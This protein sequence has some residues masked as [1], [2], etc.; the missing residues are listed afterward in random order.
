[1]GQLVVFAFKEESGAG[2]MRDALVELQRQRLINL[3]DAAVIVR[4]QDG[5]EL[6]NLPLYPSLAIG[7]LLVW[8]WPVVALVTA[9]VGVVAKVRVQLVRETTSDDA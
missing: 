9:I 4:Q 6:L 2:Q 7:G 1:M 8:L 5:S 3:D